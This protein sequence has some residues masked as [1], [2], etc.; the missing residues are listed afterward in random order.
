MKTICLSESANRLLKENL[1]KKGFELIEIEKTD[2]VYDAI[3][4]HGDIYLCKIRH[5]LVVA[6]EQLP[7]IRDELLR[8][9]VCFA[10]G[11][12]YLGNTY[13]LNVKYNAA[14]VG[15]YLIHNTHHTDPVIL[16]RAEASGLQLIHVKQGY[17]KCSLVIVDD[18][19]VITADM[20]LAAELKDHGIDVLVI[21][22]GHVNLSGFSY[23][24]L[25]GA[26]GRVDDEII[27][28]GDLS[29]HPDHKKIDSFIRQKGL[30]VTYFKSYPLEDIGSI[31]QL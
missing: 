17:T 10:A 27:F 3:S 23:G 9:N 21:S 18:H 7:L 2:A 1:R 16:S 31:I 25:G 28:N 6:L 29:A 14:Q 5:E 15:G 4:S 24:F 20:G 11:T 26:S 13:P 30:T 12:G 22:R 19:S 8:R